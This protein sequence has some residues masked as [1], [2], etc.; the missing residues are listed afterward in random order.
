MIRVTLS[1]PAGELSKVYSIIVKAIAPTVKNDSLKSG[2]YG[3]SYSQ[4]IKLKG[5]EPI[6]VIISGD[7]PE[8]L[9]FDSSTKKSQALRQKYA[10]T[11]R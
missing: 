11:G 8:G 3:K 5:T 7:L 10:Q 9:S 6:K 2:T 4:N 1:N